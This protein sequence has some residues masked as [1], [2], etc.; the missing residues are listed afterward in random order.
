MRK[1]MT[2]LVATL[3]FVQ[4]NAQDKPTSPKAEANGTVG[5][6]KVHVVY[7]QPSARGRKIMGGLVPYGEVWRTGANEATTIEFD[8]PVKIEGKEL[9]AGKY[10]LFTIPG[11]NEWTFIFNKDTKQWGA[12][13]YKQS[14][15]VLRVTAK[16]SKT[17]KFVETFVITPEKDQVK[18]EWENTAVAFKVK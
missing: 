16:P 10:S 13:N 15:D 18:L 11:E 2:L 5:P 1:L 4:G 6:A 9:A 3:F 12:Y 17:D 8:K 14:D 7:C